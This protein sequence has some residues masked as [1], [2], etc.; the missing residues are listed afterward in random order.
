MYE[1]EHDRIANILLGSYES[2]IVQ[3]QVLFAW[4]I[5]MISE[6]V[7]LRVFSCKHAYEVWNKVH[8]HFNSQ[9]KTHM[10]QLQSELKTSKK[11][12][13]SISK[14]VLRVRAIGNSLMEIGDPISEHNQVDAIL[15][16]LPE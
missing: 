4:L 3:D 2:L 1:T 7:L 16:G 10:H 12:N 5:S 15:H 8:N 6:S 13:R 9:M 11:G 14:H